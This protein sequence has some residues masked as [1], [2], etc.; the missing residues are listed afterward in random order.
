[1]K[2]IIFF[3]GCGWGFLISIYFLFSF[4]VTIIFNIGMLSMLSICINL[5]III[6]SL[7]LIYV[8][9]NFIK[10]YKVKTNEK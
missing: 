2:K 5:S 8:L 3:L 7:S 10:Q 4:S 9:L 6:F 1:M